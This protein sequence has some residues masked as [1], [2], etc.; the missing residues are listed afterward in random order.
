[1]KLTI[2]KGGYLNGFGESLYAIIQVVLTFNPAIIKIL[3]FKLSETIFTIIVCAA[4]LIMLIL[5]FIHLDLSA[6]RRARHPLLSE[7]G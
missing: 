1:M 3:D 7:V 5:V 2:L 6:P 4:Y